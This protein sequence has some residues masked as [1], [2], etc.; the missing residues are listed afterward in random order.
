MPCCGAKGDDV[1][2]LG[3]PPG[4]APD[5]AVA[6][7]LPESSLTTGHADC[8]EFNETSKFCRV[9]HKIKRGTTV[10]RNSIAR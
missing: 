10:P 2:C 7:A 8:D 4:Y 5:F 1:S 6:P 9:R 3:G